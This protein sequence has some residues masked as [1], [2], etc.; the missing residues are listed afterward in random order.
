MEKEIENLMQQT[1]LS[2]KNKK[3]QLHDMERKA[4][5]DKVTNGE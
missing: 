5:Q 2:E 1:E 4:L 3:D